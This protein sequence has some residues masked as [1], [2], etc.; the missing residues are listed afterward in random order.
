MAAYR[1]ADWKELSGGQQQR[2]SLARALVREPQLLI[3]DE[4]TTYLD[5]R[6]QQELM[7]LDL[8]APSQPGFDHFDDQ[9]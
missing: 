5:E 2:V 3:L 1:D 9:P 6:A 4:P 8:W 7:E